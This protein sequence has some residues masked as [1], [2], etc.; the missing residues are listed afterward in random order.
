MSQSPKRVRFSIGETVRELGEQGVVPTKIIY[1]ADGN[2][3]LHT[4]AASA[5]E[6]E[7]VSDEIARVLGNA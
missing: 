3:V 4:R 5:G 2:V 6:G 7:A 1:Q